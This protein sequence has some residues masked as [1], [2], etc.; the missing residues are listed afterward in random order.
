[1]LS[2]IGEALYGMGRDIERAQ[3]VVRV[4]EVTH[5]MALVR[6]SLE[7]PLT[8][9]PLYSSFDVAIDEPGE[10]ELYERLVVD[11]QHPY[12]VSRCL[13][14][15]RE[16]GRSLRDHISEEMW[17]YLNRA[18]LGLLGLSFDAIRRD[19]RSEFSFR[20]ETLCDAFHGIADDTMMHGS[21]WRFLRTGKYMERAEMTARI[22]HVKGQS[23]AVMPDAAGRPIDVH[24]WQ[25][26]LRSLAGFEPYRRWYDARILPGR[27]LEFVLRHPDFPR[28][29]GYC[30][31]RVDEHLPEESRGPKQ[32]E[33]RE[34]LGGLRRH[35]DATDV[36]SLI[37]RD[38]SAYSE[39]LMSRVGDLSSALETACFRNFYRV[40]A[41]SMSEQSRFP[42]NQ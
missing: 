34:A 28:S 4:L 17:A 29:L 25:A 2:R 15:A 36:D 38:L 14:E 10:A 19:G 9:L 23:L 22:L 32:A 20:I 39:D 3:N 16:K 24:Q 21:E 41:Q 11:P 40:T 8:W 7:D 13:R 27:V 12:S 1:M 6:Q 37:R 26:M 5:K 35:L 31:R 30:I 18:Y 42:V 33:L